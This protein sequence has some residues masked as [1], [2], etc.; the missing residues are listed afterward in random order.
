MPNNK[1]PRDWIA[2][3]FGTSTVKAAY[4]DADDKI[5]VMY[6]DSNAFTIPS[7]FHIDKDGEISIGVT[8]EEK[9]AGDSEGDV[10]P[11]K[12]K[13]RKFKKM[14]IVQKRLENWRKKKEDKPT[15]PGCP[16]AAIKERLSGRTVYIHSQS[17]QRT[18]APFSKK[19][20][21]PQSA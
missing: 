5:T 18:D 19:D 14:L 16:K 13:L 9:G 3:D 10:S 2:I 4:L 21:P 8:A 7:A 17:G 1:E 12:R 15:K 20:I 6:L 11:L